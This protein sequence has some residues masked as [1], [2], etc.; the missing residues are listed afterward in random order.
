MF[1]LLRIFVLVVDITAM[2]QRKRSP[3]KRRM[4]S[5][6]CKTL[7]SANGKTVGAFHWKWRN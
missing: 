1:G 3:G 7:K 4:L 5:A 6:A 2:P